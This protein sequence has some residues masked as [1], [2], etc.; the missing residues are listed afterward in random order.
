MIKRVD[1]I[2]IQCVTVSLFHGYVVFVVSW[3]AELVGWGGLDWVGL[4]CGW[5]WSWDLDWSEGWAGVGGGVGIWI[6]VG[7]RGVF[8]A[9]GGKGAGLGI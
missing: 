8:W 1:N 7:V 5:R 4:G 3:V 9:G 6:G 2:A